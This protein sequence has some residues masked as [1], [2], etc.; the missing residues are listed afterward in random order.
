M[1]T[2]AQ[3]SQTQILV[4]PFGM[5]ERILVV[6]MAGSGKTYNWLKIAQWSPKR[7]F[8][9]IDPDDS[10][11]RVRYGN[12]D[13][14]NR[15]FPDM[16]NINYYLT[17]TWFGKL[18]QAGPDRWMGGTIDAFHKIR[19]DFKPGDWIIV[20]QGGLL[21]ENVQSG[22]TDEVFNKDI[23]QYFLERRRAQYEQ[24]E[25]LIAS[26]KAGQQVRKQKDS[27]S[28][29]EGWKDW[30]VINKLYNADFIMPLCYELRAHV[31]M[32]STLTVVDPK[33]QSIRKEDPEIALFYAG[34]PFRI[35]GQKHV[36]VKMQSILLLAGNPNVGFVMSTFIKDRGRR[37]MRQVPIVNFPVQYLVAVGKWPVSPDS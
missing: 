5:F 35:D 11:D 6:G 29:F 30:S 18:V 21:W 4:S 32:T 1:T 34:S 25:A 36:P 27:G 10:V 23:G 22:F 13:G 2:Q 3:Q 24:D 26:Q 7:R 20:E 8:H 17:P 28:A 14:Y 19:E 31:Y 33:S 9:V 15:D 16:N 12:S 37:W